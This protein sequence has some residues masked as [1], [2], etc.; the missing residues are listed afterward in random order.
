MP[1]EA[2]IPYAPTSYLRTCPL[3][4]S[5]T[6]PEIFCIQR[7][8]VTYIPPP[9]L[10]QGWSPQGLGA[11]QIAQLIKPLSLITGSCQVQDLSTRLA[12]EKTKI[13]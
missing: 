7:M 8:Q 3:E 9:C 1:K 13:A 6:K 5:G 4:K 12:P 10:A 2:F 11:K